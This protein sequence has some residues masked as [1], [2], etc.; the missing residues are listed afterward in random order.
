MKKSQIFLNGVFGQNPIL[1]MLLGL[2]PVIVATQSI[3]NAL[4]MSV[5]VLLVLLFSNL[6]ISII[7]HI[8]EVPSEIR[9]PIYIVVIASLV[10]IV[11]L[12]MK[13]FTPSLSESLGEF[14]P[15]ITVNCIILGR[16]E[17]FASKNSVLDSVIDALGMAC[18]FAIACFI[19]AIFREFIGTG[20][21]SFS[22]PF[23]G[24]QIFSWT[25]LAD[26]ALPIMQQGA[27]GFLSFGLVIGIY[28]TISMKIQDKK[29]KKKT[30][31][32]ASAK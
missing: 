2:C 12:L 17:A 20:G 14:I 13:A 23:T 28:T 32:A 5:A 30:A 19:I 15:L 8:I 22:N 3:N 27:G 7:N 24:T 18:G 6:I 4:G 25:P 1:V 11:D 21:F 10:T 29:L 26:Y 16:A 31:I 9:I